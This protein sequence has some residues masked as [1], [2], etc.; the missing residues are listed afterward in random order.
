MALVKKDRAT[1]CKIFCNFS[2]YVHRVF[3]ILS[4]SRLR[5][6]GHQEISGSTGAATP[7]KIT[8]EGKNR[9]SRRQSKYAIAKS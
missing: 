2:C 1:G 8:S 5:K 7:N 4:V 9:G 3:G 6:L